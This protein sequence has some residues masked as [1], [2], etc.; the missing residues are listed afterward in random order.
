MSNSTDNRFTHGFS[1]HPLYD[2]YRHILKRC[3]NPNEK[4][5]I[6]YGA[7][8]I[9][10]CD[11]WKRNP[12]LFYDWSMENGYRKGLQID[13]YPDNNGNY[14]P[15]N[16]R[17]A[18]PKENSNNKRNSVRLTYM[19][20]TLTILEWSVK[21][22]IPAATIATRKHSSMSIERI[23]NPS[24]LYEWSKERK[25]RPKGLKY[26]TRSQKNS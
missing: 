20:E 18:T 3:Y 12:R 8:G 13:R 16:C 19:G 23:L 2:V 14:E 4:E 22:N 24:K 7:R 6:N 10:M 17:W 21:L 5:Y 11:E 25:P 15:G 1:K 9:K 26:K